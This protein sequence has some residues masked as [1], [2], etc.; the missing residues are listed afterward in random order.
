M[1]SPRVSVVIIN[2]NGGAF[3]QGAV[4]SLKQQTFQDFELILFDNASADGSAEK[5]DLSGLRSATLVMH[6]ENTGFA[7]GNNR[8]VEKA[9]GEW[10]VLLNPDTVA[11]PDW[12]E[13]LTAAAEAN[14]QIRTFASAQIDL[15]D[16]SLM[17]GAGDAYL[18][19][20][21]PWRGGFSRPTQEL[22]ATGLCFS[23]CGAAA[24]YDLAL[25][26]ELG[27][28][29]ERYFCYCE[30]VDLGF[31]LQLEGHD[32]LFVHDAIVR[33]A[34]SGIAGRA[35]AFATYH[36]T[37]NR[38]WTYFKNMPLP[39]LI[40]TLPG[41][42]ALTAYILIHN[43][44][45][46]RARPMLNGITDGLRGIGGIRRERAWRVTTR[47]IGL[48]QLARRMAWNPLLMHNRKVHV[49]ARKSS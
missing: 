30:D 13:K 38:I 12:L 2:Y 10:L 36:G 46:P 40:L 6:T 7:G 28:F 31:R 11:A 24:M 17:D 21:M 35:S 26:R 16:P 33:H 15:A 37:R 1:T 41:H 39:L 49:R 23:A 34:G 27:G 4:D 3:L 29:D 42:L 48:W 43:S 8:A 19:F 47:R 45:S 5:T 44:F 18:L 25:F 9:K 22:P 32:C 14:P 20:G